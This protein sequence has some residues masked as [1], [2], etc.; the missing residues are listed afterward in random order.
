MVPHAIATVSLA[1]AMLPRLAASAVDSRPARAGHAVA[2]TLRTAFALIIPF[3]L[4]L[5]VVALD[6][7]HVVIGYGAG[8]QTV[9]RLRGRRWRCSRP[10]WCSSPS[11]T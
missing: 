6:L 8:R 10:G 11:T 5:P 4:L 9:P 2:S 7:S 1:T 3:A